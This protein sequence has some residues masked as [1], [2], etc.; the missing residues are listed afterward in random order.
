MTNRIRRLAGVGV[1]AGALALSSAQAQWI[2]P[3]TN[4]GALVTGSFKDFTFDTSG[5]VDLPATIPGWYTI[6]LRVSLAHF[7]TSLGLTALD[8]W[9]VSPSTTLKVVWDAGDVGGT[10]MRGTLFS[11]A[12]VALPTPPASPYSAEYL[13]AEALAYGGDASKPTWTLKIN[14]I[15]SLSGT[16]Y[17]DSASSNPVPSGWGVR[18][19]ELI[20]IPEAHEY[21]M[22]AG[23]G[24]LSFAAY[25]RL[26]ARS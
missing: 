25:R 15:S 11:S 22:I 2:F 1:V 12:G 6:K 3:V 24:L 26:R 8:A 7:D 16:V 4:P 10:D 21:A 13:P 19:T 18:G 23:I 5:A 14:N 9:L 17:G 20:I